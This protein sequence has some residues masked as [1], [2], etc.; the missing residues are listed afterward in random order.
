[1]KILLI[2]SNNSTSPYPVYP[3]GCAVIA[4]ALQ[5]AGHKVKFL[6][7]MISDNIFDKLLISIKDFKPD[8]VGISIRN[9]DNVNILEEKCFLNIPKKITDIIHNDFPG[10][11]VILG[12]SGFS[13]MPEKLLEYI[14]ADYGVAG[15]GEK[16]FLEL[17]DNIKNG[18]K[19]KNRIFKSQNPLYDSEINGAFY[20]KSLVDFYDRKGSIMPLQTKRGCLNHCL[21]CTYPFLEGRTLR[22]RKPQDVIDDMKFLKN[23]MNADFIF[24][25]DSVFNDANLEYLKLIDAIEEAEINLPWTA[26]F[27]PDPKLDAKI[28][29][30]LI[31]AGLHSVELGPDAASNTTL[32]SIGKKFTFDDVLHCNKLFAEQQIAVANYFML[33]GPGENKKTVE[34]GVENIKKLDMSVSFVFLGIRILPGTPLYQIALQESIINK[35]TDIVQP[36]YYFSPQLERKWLEDYLDNTLTKIKHC[37]YPPNS[38][39][40]GIQILR[41]MGYRGNLWE[42]MVKNSKRLKK[43]K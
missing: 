40:A 1:M 41:Q 7:C 15:E 42:M 3:L 2:S 22:C 8:V 36:H 20:K 24:F 25:T 37:V 19:S 28:V 43:L 18:I 14:Q 39:D 10:I 13:I 26:F 29:S 16:I 5:V 30:K 31:S 11:P 27:Q 4:N 23:E 12:G 21:Y 33:G 32:K 6:D 35:D 17:L 9:I 34:E 38:M